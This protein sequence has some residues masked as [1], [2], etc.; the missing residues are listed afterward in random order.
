MQYIYTHKCQY[1]YTDTKKKNELICITI[2]FCTVSKPS[3]ESELSVLTVYSRGFRVSFRWQSPTV[4]FPR[5]LIGPSCTV[6]PPKLYSLIRTEA[7]CWWTLD[8][9]FKQI[10]KSAGMEACASVCLHNFHCREGPFNLTV[11]ERKAE[12][13]LAYQ[14][15]VGPL[16]SICCSE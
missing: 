14:E 1:I 7:F 13:Q 3:I 2:R 5:C 12:E 16:S 6:W 9:D 10:I 15:D 4:L 8:I 11:C